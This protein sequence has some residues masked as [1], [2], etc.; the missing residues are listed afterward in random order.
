MTGRFT[1]I[2]SKPWVEAAKKESKEV[3]NTYFPN[4]NSQNII[5]VLEFAMELNLRKSETDINN[6]KKVKF[7]NPA[8]TYQ[9]V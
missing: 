6:Y 7:G 8:K 3:Q 5:D 2:L 9:L 1:P 4:H